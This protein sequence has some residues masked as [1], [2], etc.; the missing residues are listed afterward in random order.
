MY[1]IFYAKITIYVVFYAEIT[2]YVIFYTEITIYV[3]FYA[4]ITIYVVFYADTHHLRCLLCWDYHLSLTIL[5]HIFT[6][7]VALSSIA[8]EN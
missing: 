4:E 2:I 1:V 3:I 7:L 6:Q 5:E 8:Q